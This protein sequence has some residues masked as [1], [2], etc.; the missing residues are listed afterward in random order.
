MSATTA[1]ATQTVTSADGTRIAYQKAGSGPPL[2]I[3]DG[4]LCYRSFGPAA[5]L[6][7]ELQQHFTVYTYDRRGR[8]ESGDTKPYSVQREVEDLQALITAAG[9]TVDMFGVSS[10]A[11]LALEATTKVDGI[12]KLALY[13]APFIVDDSHAPRLRFAET[14]DAFIAKD[15]RSGAL[16]YFM[17]T[18]GAPSI[19]VTIMSLTP[20]WRKLKAVAHTLPYDAGVLGDLGEGRPLPARRWPAATMPVLVFVGGKSP[21]VMHSAQKAIADQLPDAA[22]VTLPGQTHMVKAPVVAPKLIEFFGK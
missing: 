8:G 7:S 17:K 10:G 4:A 6:A 22:L 2:L 14:L 11:A 20:P 5:A 15:D 18:V 13:E 16:K 19:M 12:A 21:E 9:G 1:A 3:V